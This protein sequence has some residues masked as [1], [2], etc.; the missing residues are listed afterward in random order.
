M[1]KMIRIIQGNPTV[2]VVVMGRIQKLFGRSG[3]YCFLLNKDVTIDVSVAG[4][5]MLRCTW[6]RMDVVT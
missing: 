5:A 3:L 4:E 2:D 1:Q 6:S